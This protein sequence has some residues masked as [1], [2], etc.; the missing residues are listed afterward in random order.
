MKTIKRKDIKPGDMINGHGIVVDVRPDSEYSIC[1]I[2]YNDAYYGTCCGTF[3][4]ETYE[5]IEDDEK[6]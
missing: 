4:E 2:D 1:Y 6:K 5:L 3:P